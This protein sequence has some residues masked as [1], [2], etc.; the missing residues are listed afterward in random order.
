LLGRFD[1]N[2][3]VRRGSF[4]D[5]VTICD[6]ETPDAAEVIPDD[7]GTLRCGL[8]TVSVSGVL[9]WLGGSAGGGH[10]FYVHHHDNVVAE[11][12]VH[13]RYE[14][15]AF[16]RRLPWFRTR[17]ADEGGSDVLGVA[18]RGWLLVLVNDNQGRFRF[19]F[20]GPA[21]SCD[22]LREYLRQHDPIRHLDL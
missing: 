13:E 20:F 4:A 11:V 3:D 9:D 10:T 2:L 5:A 1:K 17:P 22:G 19:E 14:R 12:A 8:V 16:L 15:A 18:G 6:L 7:R 21:E